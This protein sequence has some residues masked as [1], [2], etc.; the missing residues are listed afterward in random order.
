[1]DID[2]AEAAV[3]GR[4]LYNRYGNHKKIIAAA[5]LMAEQLR[6]SGHEGYMGALNICRTAALLALYN[7]AR[8]SNPEAREKARQGAICALAKEQE[9]YPAAQ[10]E[11]RGNCYAG[12][13]LS[14][15]DWYI[16]LLEGL[17][18]QRLEEIRY[19][20][21]MD[22]AE[23][24]ASKFTWG[25]PVLNPLTNLLSQTGGTNLKIDDLRA[26]LSSADESE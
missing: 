8:S 11:F 17:N 12:I 23:P 6:H 22:T 14:D 19:H 24:P 2:L 3:E 9:L 13:I 4:L 21:A 18:T 7:S 26:V 16:R 10:P 5:P 20:Y 15:L 25:M 1:M